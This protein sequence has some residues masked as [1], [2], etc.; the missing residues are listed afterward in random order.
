METSYR[1][2]PHASKEAFAVAPGVWGL[3]TVFVNLY[4][5]ASPDGSWVLVDA[6]VYG[7][8]PKIR[9]VVDE[10]FGGKRPKAILLTHGH[11][12]HIGALKEL[13]REWEVP[14]YAHPLE[15]PYLNGKSSY[16]PPDP[17]V[18][19]GG[20][21]Y[22]SFL[23]PKKPI[24]VSEY[25]ELL[26]TDGSVPGLPDWRWVHT[27]G[28]TAGHVSFFR[29]SDRLLLAG[30]AF[31]TRDGES[32][33]AVMTQKREVHGPPKYY[34]SDWGSAHRSVEKL[35]E[36]N[37]GIAATGHGLPMEGGLL[38]RQLEELVKDFWSVAVPGQG[39]YVHEPAI[40][41]EQGVL[42]VPP[43]TDNTIPKVI[44][45][46]GIV[47]LAGVA[48]VAYARRSGQDNRRK[49]QER[50]MRVRPFSHNR[51]LQGIPPTVAATLDEDDPQ[52][53]TNNYP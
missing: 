28:H 22:M 27:P 49:Q 34:T 16:P 25:L 17:S 37:P 41:D 26:P 20:M 32:M 51:P 7:A 30:D 39:R 53:H 19:G 38:M 21:A 10:L 12:D 46:T 35:M 3:K 50:A 15:M 1:T 33:L 13:A 36:L 11:F 24:D 8:A 2:A 5:V 4:F 45:A 52:A 48:L 47:A 6:G 42:S 44:A 40:A 18:G 23:Y 31:I 14:V 43:A 29:E 9:K